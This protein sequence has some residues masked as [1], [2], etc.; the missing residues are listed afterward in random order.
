MKKIILIM[1]SIIILA[2]VTIITFNYFSTKGQFL[3]VSHTAAGIEHFDEG[4]VFYLSYD[5]MWEG[6]GNPTLE[7]V[8]FFMSDGVPA[9]E[10][11]LLIGK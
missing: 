7:N 3:K 8:E 6:V 1:L 11:D 4:R 9:N 5:L 2:S 10:S